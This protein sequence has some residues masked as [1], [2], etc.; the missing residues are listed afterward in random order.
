MFHRTKSNRIGHMKKGI[1]LG[2][3][4]EH[5]SVCPQALGKEEVNLDQFDQAIKKEGHSTQLSRL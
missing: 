3:S 4:V 1:D 2:Q 5:I